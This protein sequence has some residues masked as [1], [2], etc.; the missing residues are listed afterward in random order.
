MLS[1][2]WFFNVM[3]Q[4]LP[5]VNCFNLRKKNNVIKPVTKIARHIVATNDNKCL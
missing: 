2:L 1:K 4:L 5:T 3:I